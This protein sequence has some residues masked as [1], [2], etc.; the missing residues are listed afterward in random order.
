MEFEEIKKK[1]EKLKALADR[2]ERGERDNAREQLEK[3]LKRHG[4]SREDVFG[5]EINRVFIVTTLNESSKILEKVIRSIN[6]KA[7]M[8]VEQNKSKLT[9]KV[10]LSDAEYIEVKQKYLYFWRSFNEEKQLLFSAFLNKHSQYFIPE[11]K[12]TKGNGGK[13]RNQPPPPPPDLEPPSPNGG[14]AEVLSN[15]E[16]Q[17]VIKMMGALRDLQYTKSS[18]MIDY[19]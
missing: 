6:P 7:V 9:I 11:M 19:E 8:S 4:L 18:K 14:K 13:D 5:H 17:R 12:P 10:A 1:A 15:K 3:L 16:I 2:G